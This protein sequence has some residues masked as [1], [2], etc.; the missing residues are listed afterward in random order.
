[1][2]ESNFDSAKVEKFSVIKGSSCTHCFFK[3]FGCDV[4]GGGTGDAA[5][6]KKLDALYGYC[7]NGH[8]YELK[9]KSKN[10][11]FNSHK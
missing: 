11:L 6:L 2:K 7:S 10:F 3:K 5:V 9:R 1:M 8:H 4:E